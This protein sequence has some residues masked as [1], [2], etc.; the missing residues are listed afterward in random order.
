MDQKQEQCIDGQ[1][2]S[3]SGAEMV[4]VDP[5]T[6]RVIW[7]GHESGAEQIDAAVA[8]AR[9]AF[10]PW[11]QLTLEQRR[12]HLDQFA[13]QLRTHR[14]SLAKLISSE[15]GKPHWESLGEV[16]A[17]VAKIAIT[18]E[19]CAHRCAEQIF[20]TPDARSITRFKPQGVVV[21][22][23]PFNLP[24]HLPNGHIVP[25]LLLGNAVVFKPSELTPAVGGKMVSLWQSAGLPPGLVNL[26]QGGP[27]VGANLVSHKQI[28][29]V[30]FTGSYAAGQAINRAV[31]DR[32]EMVLALEMGGNNPLVVHCA[33][34]L[35]AAAYLTV[36]SAYITSGQRCSCAR[37]LI[38]VNGSET[39]DFLQRLC[40][41]IDQIKVGPPGDSV[42][43][44]MGSLISQ[45]A[46]KKTLGF[47]QA[48]CERGGRVL[49][50][51][52]AMDP[53]P[54]M[55]RPGL[56]DVSGVEDCGDEEV[57]GPLLQL[58]R[59][60]NFDE[61]IE[62][63]NRTCYGLAAG[64]LCGDGELYRHFHR[65]VRAGV[66]NW[67]RQTT[68]ASSR[69]PFGGIGRSGNH[70]PSGAYAVDYCAYPVASLESQTLNMPKTPLPGILEPV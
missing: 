24:G 15:T 70:R 5:V 52:R 18:I 11:S 67:N 64:L 45:A 55:L 49:I 59:V 28:D 36:L 53:S 2:L 44:F 43:P 23:G 33:G 68:G 29:G 32:P 19:M 3:G 25:A 62:Q 22:L 65:R 20:D 26:V 21:V 66:I 34:E 16:D 27:A 63:A 57:F 69:L 54:A 35:D 56:V 58:V 12:R 48:L 61:A 47:Q 13:N 1:W 8:A 42:E 50:E 9:T 6:G 30:Y 37:R 39:E 10:E 17:M 31:A 4:S 40:V 7:N 60:N 14:T 38:V 51:S 46:A 41:M